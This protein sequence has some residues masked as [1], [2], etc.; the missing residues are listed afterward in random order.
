MI[1]HRDPGQLWALIFNILDHL[2]E[3]ERTK[4]LTDIIW[5]INSNQSKLQ[6]NWKRTEV[7]LKSYE[8][9]RDESLEASLDNMRELV[10]TLSDLN[11]LS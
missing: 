3:L 7:L 9:Y 6:N 10:N 8:K 4:V 11:N 1:N 5:E 2:E